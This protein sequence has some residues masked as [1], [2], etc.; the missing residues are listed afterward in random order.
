MAW[1][2]TALYLLFVSPV[3]A[4][5]LL[6]IAAQKAEGRIGVTVWGVRRMASFRLCRN[7]ANQPEILVLSEKS[8]KN[9]NR[10]I[11]V[12]L[13]SGNPEFWKGGWSRPGVRAALGRLVS[14]FSVTAE[15]RIGGGNA[16][17]TAVLSGLLSMLGAYLPHV[18]I[19]C[20]P[21]YNG[22]T[23][24]RLSCI[25][26]ARLGILIAVCLRGWLA[27]R[28]NHEKRSKKRWIVPSGT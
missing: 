20:A 10:E 19:R 25:G 8:G 16:A 6:E 14:L 24:A 7:E 28:I 11:T 2:L 3:R 13:R 18:R 23:K 1:V 4:G 22:H 21:Q 26:Q 27:G 15:I 9:G 17:R 5:L 12:P